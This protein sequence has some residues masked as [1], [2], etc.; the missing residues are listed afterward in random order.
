MTAA[1]KRDEQKPQ[2]EAR[3][4]VAGTT[5]TVTQTTYTVTRTVVTTLPP[6]TTTEARRF[7]FLELLCRC[8]RDTDVKLFYLNVVLRITTATM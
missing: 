7:C 2:T 1:E 8:G 3:V 4:A 5:V 6:E